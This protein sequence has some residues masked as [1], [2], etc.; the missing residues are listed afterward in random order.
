M[1]WQL[2]HS[3]HIEDWNPKTGVIVPI[4]I[5]LNRGRF[6]LYRYVVSP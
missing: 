1:N 2:A 4:S 5:G 6:D 3:A